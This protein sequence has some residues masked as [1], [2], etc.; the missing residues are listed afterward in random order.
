MV[1]GGKAQCLGWHLVVEYRMYERALHTTQGS[2][3]S[4][5]GRRIRLRR[6][7]QRHPIPVR[8]RPCDDVTAG[9][10]SPFRVRTASTASQLPHFAQWRVT[11]N[12]LGRTPAGARG[13]SQLVISTRGCKGDA[14]Y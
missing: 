6:T 4:V 8:M 12:L 5:S 13:T 2:V 1:R 9:P 14:G 3:L 10:E 11:K 7:H